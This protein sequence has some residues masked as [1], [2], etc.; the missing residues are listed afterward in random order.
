MQPFAQTLDD[1]RRVG[2]PGVALD[3][4]L[5]RLAEDHENARRLAYG[6]AQLPG[7][8]VDLASVQTNIVMFDVLTSEASGFVRRLAERQVRVNAIGP[9]RIRAVTHLDVT[10]SD[11]DAALDQFALLLRVP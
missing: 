10:T 4:H 11:I 1:A 6:L 2:V 9:K 7:I 3:H 8:S 5:P